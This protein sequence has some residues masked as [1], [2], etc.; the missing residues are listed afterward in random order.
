M[1]AIITA[2]TG[3]ITET[4]TSWGY[5]G[6]VVLMA[7]ESAAIPLPSEIILPFAGSLVATGEFTLFGV[8]LA[9][10]IGC[11]IGSFITYELG[12]FGGRALIE[13]YGRYVLL[14]R[15]ELGWAERFVE[16]YGDA[17]TF[18]T[19]LL[20]L[21]R[22]YISIPAGILRIPRGKFLLYTFLGSFI[23]SWFLAYLGQQLGPQWTTLRQSFHG[24]DTAL[25]VAILIGIALF[26]FHR[27]HERR[28]H[29]PN[30]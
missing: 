25:A 18:I 14:S 4:I 11:V 1:E 20:P 3:F 10:A 2:V 21:I 30:G 29:P 27:L 28:H 17:S 16:K 9:G 7:I 5:A 13:R 6:V 8:A 23:W 15:R 22:T 12:Y 19:R 26:I 24:L